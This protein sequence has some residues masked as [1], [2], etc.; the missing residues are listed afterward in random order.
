MTIPAGATVAGPAA[1]Q[2]SLH[3]AHR[4]YEGLGKPDECHG[5]QMR[6]GNVERAN[7][8]HHP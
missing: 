4:P 7:R 1:Y 3:A 5:F 6:T 2:C 8:M